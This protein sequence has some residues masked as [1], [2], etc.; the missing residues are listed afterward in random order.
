MK[1]DE[2][3]GGGYATKIKRVKPKKEVEFKRCGACFMCGK[4]S[5]SIFCSNLCSILHKKEVTCG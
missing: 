1:K 2:I 5:D 4:P 3:G